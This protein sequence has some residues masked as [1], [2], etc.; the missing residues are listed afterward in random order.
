M[1]MRMSA[2]PLTGEQLLTDA[3]QNSIY[4]KVRPFYPTRL[5]R[6]TFSFTDN[7]SSASVVKDEQGRPFIVV[8]EYVYST[9]EGATGDG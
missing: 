1:A 7:F 8:R 5:T 6:I 9:S 2:I 3:S 4:R